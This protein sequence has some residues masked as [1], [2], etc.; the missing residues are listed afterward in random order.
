MTNMR[1]P[2][3]I[4]HSAPW[5]LIRLWI[6]KYWDTDLAHTTSYMC[7]VCS[8]KSTQKY[9]ALDQWP[10]GQGL[11]KTR[12]LSCDQN[13]QMNASGDHSLPSTQ[14]KYRLKVFLISNKTNHCSNLRK[15]THTLHLHTF[16]GCSCQKWQIYT[17][18][19]LRFTQFFRTILWTVKQKPQTFCFG[20]VWERE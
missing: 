1:K 18:L 17:L 8:D 13:M 10:V 7:H 2:I 6:G 11:F 3:L 4:I 19:L 5:T 15:N 9:R 16:V 14:E 20:D 12:C